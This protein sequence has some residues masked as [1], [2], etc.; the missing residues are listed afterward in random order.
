MSPRD[1]MR[2]DG[3]PAA[4]E[5]P[6]PPRRLRRA[7]FT[8]LEMMTVLGVIGVILAI[9]VPTVTKARQE[10]RKTTAK[11]RLEI[12]SSAVVQLA[13][14]TGKWPG[15]IN[16]AVQ[17]SAEVWDL[18]TLAS[19]LHSLDTRFQNWQ[20]PYCDQVPL[21]PWGMPYF[22]DPDYR[23]R[24]VD[25]VVLGSFGPNKVGRNAYDSD[26]IYVIVK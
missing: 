10:S 19:G 7:G 15:G 16:R 14:D 20:G 8:A 22:F 11:A 24:G 5:H 18:N 25:R 2:R 26:D 13:W 23:V 12:L 6:G 9:A 21:D 3:R 4:A 1:T 17:Q